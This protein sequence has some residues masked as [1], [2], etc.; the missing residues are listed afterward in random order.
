MKINYWRPADESAGSETELA[1][2]SVSE[3]KK[4]LKEKGGAA[5][6]C[7]FDRDG[8]YQD[9]WEIT[10]GKNAMSYRPFSEALKSSRLGRRR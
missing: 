9:T 7:L 5:W 10:L 4:L 6:T 2:I 3:A 8:S 1:G